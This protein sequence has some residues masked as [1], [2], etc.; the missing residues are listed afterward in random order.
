MKLLATILLVSALGCGGAPRAAL[1]AAPAARGGSTPAHDLRGL[2]LRDATQARAVDLGMVRI[3]VVGTDADG[4]P[5]LDAI[6]PSQLLDDGNRAARGGRLGAALA[7][8][9]QIVAEFAD[10]A[11]APVA[12]WNI[13]AV[14]SQRGEVED[15]LAALQQLLREFPTAPKSI[16][17]AL[18]LGGVHAERREWAAADQALSALFARKDL[19][20]EVQIEAGARL[21]Y[22]A[23]ERGQ[24]ERA[25]A[26]LDAAIT[27]WRRAQRVEDP[28]Y[29]AMAHYYRGELIRRRFA[30]T[31][32]RLG[33][34]QQVD[35]DSKE[36]LAAAAYDRWKEVLDFHH[37]YWATAA[38][39][40][41]SE[42]FVEVW[43]TVVQA[44]LP[45]D[46]SAGAREPYV[47]EVHDRMRDHLT[48]AL[49]GHR[50]NAELGAAYGVD[51]VWSGASRRRVTDLEAILE[52]EARGLLAA[53]DLAQASSEK[54]PPD[55]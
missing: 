23:L 3:E 37:A 47:R 45:V 4:S 11:V 53:P 7:L 18:H 26:T 29:I 52:R 22:V 24:L 30:R 42:I 25:E 21:G 16:D 13:A 6:A 10:S 36:K 54:G 40:Q 28:Y 2:E 31:P 51:T 15:S 43:R 38:G 35:L 19:T 46:L 27:A 8:Y 50:V 5:H 55:R 48:Q 9:R 20:F 44:P 33:P 41:M 34:D 39:Y 17:A 32:L 49:E 1:P 14:H 12:L